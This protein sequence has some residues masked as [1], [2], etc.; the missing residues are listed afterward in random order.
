[1]NSD[2]IARRV[3]RHNLEAER[4]LSNRL[5][6]HQ[7]TALQ[8]I[9]Q[10]AIPAGKPS[11]EVAPTTLAVHFLHATVKF[12]MTLTFKQVGPNR[13]K[14]NH[15]ATYLGQMSFSSKVWI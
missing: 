15:H 14:L 8:Q 5:N 7:I 12:D 9:I 13:V 1:V 2:V 3:E 6:Q 11:L 4:L 10:L